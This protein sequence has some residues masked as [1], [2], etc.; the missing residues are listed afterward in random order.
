MLSIAVGDKHQ[1][2]N[3][4]QLAWHLFMLKYVCYLFAEHLQL[5]EPGLCSMHGGLDIG[6]SVMEYGY[7]DSYIHG[8]QVGLGKPHHHTIFT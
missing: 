7:V 8:G 3:P 2:K 5:S 6:W 4:F 1:D